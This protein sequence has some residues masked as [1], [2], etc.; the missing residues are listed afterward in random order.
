LVAESFDD[1]ALRDERAYRRRRRRERG[2]LRTV[3]HRL[4]PFVSRPLMRLNLALFP[5]CY[6]LYMR[7]VW[8]TSAIHDKGLSRLFEISAAHNGAVGLLWHEE[9]STVAWGYAYMGF[10]PHTLASLS[11]DG[12]VI[13]RLLERCGFVVFRGGS[14]ERDSRRRGDVTPQLIEHMR[15]TD[16]VIYGLTV[17]GSKGP[18]YRIKRGGIVVARE[19]G[20]PIVLVRTWYRRCLRLSTW[21]RSA[22]PLPFNRIHYYLEGPFFPPPD[23]DTEAGLERFRLALESALVALAARSYDE[24]GQPRPANLLTREQEQAQRGA[25]TA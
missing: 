10:R 15:K 9:V 20:K 14:S 2:W 4:R 22:I 5:V 8:A 13:T 18:P 1:V 24:L 21:D 11:N 3:R 25:G 16:G 19:C 12:A 7:L 6:R 23:A 17:D